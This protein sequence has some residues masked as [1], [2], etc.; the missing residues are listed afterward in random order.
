MDVPL[1]IHSYTEGHL[2]C[3][4]FLMI[5]NKATINFIV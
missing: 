1:F 5:M 3:A 4:Q 2:G